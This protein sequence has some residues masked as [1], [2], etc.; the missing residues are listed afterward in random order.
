[1]RLEND[2]V[3]RLLFLNE[4]PRNLANAGHKNDVGSFSNKKQIVMARYILYSR[5]FFAL[6]LLLIQNKNYAQDLN[7]QVR[8]S[9]KMKIIELIVSNSYDFPAHRTYQITDSMLYYR[10]GGALKV[11]DT[12]Q[13]FKKIITPSANPDDWRIYPSY[14]FADIPNNYIA[15][16]DERPRSS[17]DS[18]IANLKSILLLGSDKYVVYFDSLSPTRCRVIGG[19]C[20][21]GFYLGGYFYR[22]ACFLATELKLFRF[23]IK[24]DF[25]VTL[26]NDTSNWSKRAY[27]IAKSS[28]IFKPGKKVLID[29]RRPVDETGHH[30]YSDS[31][32]VSVFFYHDCNGCPEEGWWREYLYVSDDPPSFDFVKLKKQKIPP[33]RLKFLSNPEFAELFE[34]EPGRMPKP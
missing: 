7:N 32:D 10:E 19:A 30:Q 21:T 17:K 5:L 18:A 29:S 34:H 33:Q 11:L 9:L 14:E 22:D 12:A 27:F 6:Y 20:K 1:V 15:Y 3:F 24:G 23:D 2:R 31:V 16:I 4:Q 26:E 25:P 8:L 13:V 28:N